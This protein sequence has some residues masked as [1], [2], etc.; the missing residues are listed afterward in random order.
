MAGSV[1]GGKPDTSFYLS[2]G[3]TIILCGYKNPGSNP[4][5]YSEFILSICEQ[6]TIIGFWG[7]ILTC[8]LKANKDTL[9]V[10]Q[11][12]HLPTGKDNRFQPTLWTTEKI[13]FN[14]S[15]TLRQLSINR[16]IQKYSATEIAQINKN[17]KAAKGKIDDYK[18]NL[19]NY[20]FVATISG[21]TAARQYFKEFPIKFGPLDGAFKEE[22][23]DLTAMLELWDRKE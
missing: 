18:M 5:T 12:E 21:D 4:T 2:N 19:L 13:Y 20:L 8:R 11:L 7:A 3:K 17:F 14:G 1:E 6:D 16:E 9:F 22:Y 10:E 15:K 23:S